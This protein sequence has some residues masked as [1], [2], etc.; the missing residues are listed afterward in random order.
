MN[1]YDEPE[2]RWF[3]TPLEVKS[4]YGTVSVTDDG[5]L[6]VN[7]MQEGRQW[8]LKSDDG[9]FEF[10]FENCQPG[11]GFYTSSPRPYVTYGVQETLTQWLGWEETVYEIAGKKTT[12]PQAE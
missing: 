6:E 3:G 12:K 8:V 11:I 4:E 2:D 9:S 10:E 5:L 7:L 1:E